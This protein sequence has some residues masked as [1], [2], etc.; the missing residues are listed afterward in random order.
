MN[1][2][3][4]RILTAN[5]LSRR[6]YFAA[7]EAYRVRRAARGAGQYFLN[8]D[9]FKSALLAHKGSALVD[10]RTADG[11]TITIRR[12]Y[13]DAMTV[14]EIFL[15]NCYGRD[16]RLPPNPVVVDVGGF[17]GD[18]SLYAV[19]RLN[20]R[21]VIVCEPSPRNWTLL[22]KNIA[23]NRYEDR[24]EPV[25]KAV[26]DGGKAIMMN[27]DA[28]DEHQCMVSAYYP[29]EQPSSIVPGISLEQ[30]FRDHSVENV[31]LLKIDCEGGE[32]AI[33]ESTPSEVLSRIQ[34]IVFEYHGIGEAWS[35]LENV[36]QRLRREGYV[37]LMHGGLV[38][39]SRPTGGTTVDGSFSE[40]RAGQ[41]VP[42]R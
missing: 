7:R 35:K 5:S 13:G 34:N 2:T 25:N 23:N 20:A 22:L 27:I 6:F 26:T 31:D 11:L 38:C 42:T 28:P 17:I 29:S 37:L 40:T 4:R 12:N 8:A 9:Q 16:L 10:L 21:R 36:K 15:D 19:K 33:L 3:I 41:S 24:I 1:T 39:A 32:Y 30:L 18:F 14:G